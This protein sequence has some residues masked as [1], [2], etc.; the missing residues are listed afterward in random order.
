MNTYKSIETKSLLITLFVRIFS[1]RI[2]VVFY[3]IIM[4][5]LFAIHTARINLNSTQW[6]VTLIV[7]IILYISLNILS[8][9]ADKLNKKENDR[10][11]YIL[12]AYELHSSINFETANNLYR[13][14]KKI[15]RTIRCNQIQ[16]EELRS[17]VD[18]QKLSFSICN[19]LYNFISNICNCKE[20]EVSIFQRFT[21]NDNKDYVKMIAYKNGKNLIPS[22]YNTEFKLSHKTTTQVPVFISI[23]ND[24]NAEIKILENKEAVKQDFIFFE[25]SK[26]REERIC[27]YI[28]IPIKTNRGKIEVV[29]QIDVSKDNVMGCNYNEVKQFAD[30]IIKPF[31]NLLYCSYERDLI[32]DKF[33]DIIEENINGVKK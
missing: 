15:N 19:E 2:I 33:Y 28:G 6:V 20:C 8:I 22:T 30:I 11:K 5:T 18:F 4:T 26:I 10:Q 25:N 32:L 31:V 29:L 9:F 3:D 7:Y 17:V 27:Q 14:N 24:L 13:V 12:E 21:N 1:N 16:K 23:F